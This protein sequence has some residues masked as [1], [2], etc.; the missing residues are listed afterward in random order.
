MESKLNSIPAIDAEYYEA[1]SLEFAQASG[2]SKYNLGRKPCGC[3]EDNVMKPNLKVLIRRRV[4]SRTISVRQD[5]LSSLGSNAVPL[6]MVQAASQGEGFNASK[7][8]AHAVGRKSG[9]KSSTCVPKALKRSSRSVGKKS[10]KKSG[11]GSLGQLLD[12]PLVCC[13]CGLFSGPDLESHLKTCTWVNKYPCVN[14]AH[15][16]LQMKYLASGLK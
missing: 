4:L 5:L 1:T 10:G 16:M 7:R 13:F 14:T 11:K 2:R 3:L 6:G 12:F 9:K 15:I 8:G